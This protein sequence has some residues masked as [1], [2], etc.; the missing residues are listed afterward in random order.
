M[1]VF[2][3][4]SNAPTVIIRRVRRPRTAPFRPIFMEVNFSMDVRELL[5]ANPHTGPPR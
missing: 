4:S 2:E 1:L 5:V 3:E